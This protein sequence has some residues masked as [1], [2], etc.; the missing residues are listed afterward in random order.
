MAPYFAGMECL[1]DKNIKR[2]NGS[3]KRYIARHA[4]LATPDLAVMS[5]RLLVN[6]SQKS[7][8]DKQVGLR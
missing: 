6:E 4:N 1:F 2:A 7:S 5:T 8:N 3:A